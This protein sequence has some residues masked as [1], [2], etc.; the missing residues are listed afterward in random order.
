MSDFINQY[1]NEVK[2][3][4]VII[5]DLSKCKF[6]WHEV[7]NTE[8]PMNNNDYMALKA[9]IQTV[10]Q[11]KPVV[12]FND[13]VIDGRHRQKICIEL[14]MPLK[15][16]KLE[17]HYTI[18]QLREI[19]RSIHMGRNKTSIQM[20]IQAYRYK[21]VVSN[22]TWEE[23][24]GKY[25]VKVITIKRINTLYNLLYL[26]GFDGDFERVVE[27]LFSGMNLLPNSFN[28]IN[29]ATSSISSAI[30]QFKEYLSFQELKQK[31]LDEIDSTEKQIIVD[32]DTG[33]VIK[34]DIKKEENPLI[35]IVK[36][37]EEN[38]KLKTLLSE[39]DSKI[40]E[41]EDRLKRFSDV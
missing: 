31:E 29:K 40:K 36:V 22:V 17:R 33:E 4:S 28:W 26:N 32:V 15:I 27:T 3:N 37:Q 18:P 6:K 38:K 16:V 2:T 14:N 25:G 39:K 13:L 34:Q 9:N 23:S 30:T 8:P 5:V 19:V 7:S 21:K 1:L 10:G 35:K 12:L 41:L 11:N 24:A 20:Q